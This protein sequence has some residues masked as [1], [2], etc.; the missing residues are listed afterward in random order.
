MGAVVH[1]LG[2]KVGL[3]IGAILSSG[4]IF[5]FYLIFFSM[6]SILVSRK[7]NKIDTRLHSSRMRTARALTVSPSM[8]WAV[9]LVQGECVPGQGLCTWSGG[10]CCW[11]GGVYLV[12]GVVCLVWGWWCLWSGGW[13]AWSGGVPGLGVCAWSGGWSDPPVNTIT[14]T[15]KNITLPQ[16]RCGR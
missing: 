16:L 13:C 8:G 7:Q 3:V 5:Y 15:C 14:H 2:C 11:S 9:C 12:W 4:E 6:F 1:R 10:W